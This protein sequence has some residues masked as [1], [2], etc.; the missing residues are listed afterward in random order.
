M[1]LKLGESQIGESEKTSV[2]FLLSNWNSMLFSF[3]DV[4]RSDTMSEKKRKREEF[5]KHLTVMKVYDWQQQ[6]KDC[7]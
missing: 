7:S 4:K 1:K 5:R 3:H 6:N 2:I